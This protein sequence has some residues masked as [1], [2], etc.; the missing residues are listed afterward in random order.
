MIHYYTYPCCRQKILKPYTG[1]P[2]GAKCYCFTKNNPISSIIFDTL[3]T[4]V[5]YIVY[6]MEKGAEG[7]YHLQ[8]YI[9][10]NSKMTI[11]AITRKWPTFLNTHFE[12]A[13]GT[14]S[15]NKAYCTKAETREDGPWE[16]GVMQPG[17]GNRTD[18]IAAHQ[19]MLT[20]GNLLDVDP[21]VAMKYASSCLKIAANAPCPRR[22]DLKV[23]T[24]IGPSGIGKS[25]A[26]WACYPGLYMP[27]YGNCGMWWD[28]YNGQ[29]TVLIEEFRGQ[30]PLQRML[31]LLDLY[32][33]RLEVKGG[34]VP[35]RFKLVIITSNTEP[36]DW[37]PDNPMKAGATRE[38]E[39]QALARRLGV[40]TIRYI[41]AESRADLHRQLALALRIE[42]IIA[43]IVQEWLP[44]I[45]LVRAPIAR[46]PTSP[47]PDTEPPPKRNHAN[48]HE[49]LLFS[50]SG[51]DP[52][53]Y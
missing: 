30:V 48:L 6:Q 11:T 39:R 47:S 23:I 4:E 22:D 31:Q 52:D 12:V 9:Q 44:A 25:H 41:K 29:E 8:G 3:P 5:V 15:Q 34:A 17:S 10:F 46:V 2:N 43:P 20:T 45:P 40:G 50:P 13:R 28:G 1:M 16:F 26:A 36:Q 42:G 51:I 18:L 53:D 32:P 7:T 14:P 24:I 27:Y 33:L 35:A 37:Y 19:T 49:Y 21:A 38:P